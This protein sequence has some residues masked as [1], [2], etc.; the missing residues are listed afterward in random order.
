MSE[1]NA[2]PPATDVT[3]VVCTR[4]RGRQ[5]RMCLDAIVGAID[6]QNRP[7]EVVLV[8]NGSTD[9]T[10]EVAR[11]WAAA[12]RFPVHVVFEPR[13]GLSI[14]RNTALRHAR[15]RI[16]VFTDDDCRLA[17]DYLPR[18]FHHYDN[19]FEPVIRGGRVELGDA[20]DAEFT[21]KRDRRPAR[22]LDIAEV[23]SA[24][25]FII[26]CN[27]AMPREAADRIGRFDERFGAG[28]PFKAAEDT[29]FICRAFL[30][31]IPVEYA[32]D[33]VVFHHHGR[34]LPEDIKKLHH[35]YCIA[36]GALYAKYCRIEW[37]LLRPLYWDCRK[38]MFELLGGTTLHAALGL[39]YRQTIFGN[40]VGMCS[41]GVHRL[42]AIASMRSR[43]GKDEVRAT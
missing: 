6:N 31:G 14:A 13:P 23:V 32:P 36:K 27:M 18:L 17:P 30:A 2:N 38:G 3:I 9:D 4:N 22:L 21:T 19:D 33:L 26:G 28:G 41:Y 43:R 20:D 42:R 35:D 24:A 16:I 7:V 11:N 34:R 12:A 15:G 37:R 29:D 8:D 40:V 1:S 25:G 5:L 10:G 39:T